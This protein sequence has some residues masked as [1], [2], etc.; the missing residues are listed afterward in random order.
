LACPAPTV[1]LGVHKEFV[2]QADG[3]RDRSARAT[4]PHRLGSSGS[5]TAK[6]QVTNT[7]IQDINAQMAGQAMEDQELSDSEA[8]MYLSFALL[9][10]ATGLGTSI[11]FLMWIHRAHRN[12]P[13]LG[14]RD[15]RFTPGWAVG[16]FFI[17]IMNLFRPY[18]VMREVWAESDPAALTPDPWSGDPSPPRGS[19]LVG[20]WWGL[21]L[22]MEFVNQAAFRASIRAETPEASLAAEWVSMVGDL[23]TFPAAIVAIRLVQIITRNQ[24]DRH[25]VLSGASPVEAGFMMS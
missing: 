21:Y 10:I 7:S 5:R 20:W 18:Q 2:G 22:I 13:S 3:V 23:I 14:A 19:S 8:M 15:L 25:R 24:E 17:P 12:L 1:R 6:A 11:A 9:V 4:R 16:W